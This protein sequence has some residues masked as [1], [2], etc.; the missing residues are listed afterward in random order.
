MDLIISLI[1]FVIVFAIIWDGLLFIENK[2]IN[3]KPLMSMNSHL[4]FGMKFIGLLIFMFVSFE[5]IKI[6]NPFIEGAFIGTLSAL[7]S[8]SIEV[9]IKNK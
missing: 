8:K 9:L 2:W 3:I 4:K 7:L 6:T 1:T 5:I